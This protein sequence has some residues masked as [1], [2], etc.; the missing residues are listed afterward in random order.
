MEG[1]MKWSYFNLAKLFKKLPF[2]LSGHDISGEVWCS[3]MK[4]QERQVHLLLYV[5]FF[6][7]RMINFKYFFHLFHF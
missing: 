3:Q 5:P 1:Q 7:S 2:S 4:G 6:T